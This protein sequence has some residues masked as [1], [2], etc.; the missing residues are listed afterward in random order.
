MR[1]AALATAVNRDRWDAETHR[2]IGVGA[3]GGE[4]GGEAECAGGVDSGADE[5]SRVGLR[6]CRTYPDRVH[7]NA[8]PHLR[9][10]P[11]RMFPVER[12]LECRAEARVERIERSGRFGSQIDVH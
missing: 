4:L 3:A 9:L 6:T 5:P 7:P 10:R 8:E 1:A 11:S 2:K 12:P